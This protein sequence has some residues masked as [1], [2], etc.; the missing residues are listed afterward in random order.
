MDPKKAELKNIGSKLAEEN[1][2]KQNKEMSGALKN[3]DQIEMTNGPQPV[4]KIK[5]HD[6][7][8][9]KNELD[10]TNDE[11]KNI[12]LK[13]Q[14]DVNKAIDEYLNDFNLE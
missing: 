14:G 9:L 2:D 6:I 7:D 10:I 12:L 1:N 5:E 3:L 4:I 8:L 11:A 13:Y